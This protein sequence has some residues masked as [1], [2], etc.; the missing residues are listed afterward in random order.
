MRRGVLVGVL[1]ILVVLLSSFASGYY[2]KSTSLTTIKL[3]NNVDIRY[4]TSPY[5]NFKLPELYLD[6]YQCTDSDG[7]INPYL[8]GVVWRISRTPSHYCKDWVTQFDQL[9]PPDPAICEF[10]PAACTA[11][12][13][14]CASVRLPAECFGTTG[15]DTCVG[16]SMVKEYYCSGSDI[17]YRYISCPRGCSRGACV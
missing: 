17:R 6:P 14:Y 10:N 4:I 13:A 3:L 16:S 9:C 11:I 7:G 2:T 15:V 12:L 1:V 5:Y 8:R